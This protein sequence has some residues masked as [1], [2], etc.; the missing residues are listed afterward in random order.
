MET[1]P[2]DDYSLWSCLPELGIDY[3]ADNPAN[4]ADIFRYWYL[5]QDSNAI[6]LDADVVVEKMFEPFKNDRPYFSPAHPGALNADNWAIH[7]NGQSD[8]FKKIWG[9][10]G[11]WD[12]KMN[13][14]T[15]IY[16]Y[17]KT[18]PEEYYIIPTGYYNHLSLKTW[19]RV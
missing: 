3:G 14:G 18:I 4:R 15:F 11:Q 2:K 8:F 6:F 7:G 16:R 10:V 17:L 19:R 9:M 5:T 1:V 13:F 12:R